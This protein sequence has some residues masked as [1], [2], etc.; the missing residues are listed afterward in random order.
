MKANS[1]WGLRGAALVGIFALW[2][3]TGPRLEVASAPSQPSVTLSDAGIQFTAL[4]NTWNGYPG[5]LTSYYTPVEVRIQNDRKEEI[6]VRYGDFLLIDDAQNQYQ[7]VAPAE[8]ARALIGDRWP[9]GIPAAGPVPSPPSLVAGPWWPYGWPYYS[10]YPYGPFGPYPFYPDYPYWWNRSIGYDI[11]TKALREGRILPGAQVQGFLYFQ[12]ATQKGR[13]LTL[14]W[15]PLSA[16]E[17][18]LT[19]FSIQLRIVR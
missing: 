7:A 14:T 8:V 1:T 10:W 12:N 11:L 18:P 5:D 3:C 16:N 17:K 2:A 19:T 15:T 6:Q 13:L 4:P 9:Y